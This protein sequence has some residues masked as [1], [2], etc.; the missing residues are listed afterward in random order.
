MNYIKKEAIFSQKIFFMYV[1]TCYLT[2][3]EQLKL[4]NKKIQLH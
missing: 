3:C 2:T 4:K 1:V